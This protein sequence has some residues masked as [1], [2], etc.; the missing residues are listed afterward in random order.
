VN[1]AAQAAALFFSPSKLTQ[2]RQMLGITRAELARRANLSAAAVSQYESGT[3]RPR[4]KSLAELALALE[5][6]VE[7]L[8][9]RRDPPR[10]PLGDE[11]F[12]R[13]LRRTSKRKRDQ[14]VA[15]AGL[16]AQL[17]S[18][19]ERH[20][21]LP[22]YEQVEGM[23]MDP[24]DPPEHAEKAAEEIRARWDLGSDPVPHV[25][26]LLE[27][28]GLIVTR[29]PLS[30]EVDAFSWVAGPRPLVLLGTDKRDFERSRFDA[31]HELAH[32]VLHAADPEPA[33]PAMEKQAHR[34]AGALLIPEGAIRN[35]W[36]QGR[37][38]WSHLVEI[39]QRWGIS[40][41]ALLIRGRHL[42]LISPSQYENRMKYM[43][44]M[45]WR[46]REPGGG[47]SPERPELLDQALGLLQQNGIPL[48]QL[49]AEGKLLPPARLKERL[50]LS[51]RAPVTVIPS[52]SV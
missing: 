12:F 38:N 22:A 23:A 33:N 41:G 21:Q 11:A 6:P 51:P 4:G 26:R 1:T 19:I 28:R 7:F 47:T 44:R 25:V 46:R 50:G 9:D 3:S 49:A 39:K 8:T 52:D 43:S 29:L 13:S 32:V 48:E 36:P 18:E 37:W 31:A 5:V 2:A 35:E 17:V 42:G 27:R 45:G 14:A 10:L 40:I 20:A 15:Y 30:E 16:V 34:F 24:D